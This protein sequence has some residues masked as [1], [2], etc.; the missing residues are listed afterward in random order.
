MP[1]PPPC[2]LSEL[3]E[4]I[5]KRLLDADEEQRVQRADS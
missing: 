2:R 1:V 3:R 5:L 4:R